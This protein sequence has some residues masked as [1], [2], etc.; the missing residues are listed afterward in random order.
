[1]K[2]LDLTL[3]TAAENV[4]LD[5]ALLEQA[6]QGG[7]PGELLRLW[8]LSS[9][10]VVIGRS[11]RLAEEVNVGAC[12]EL[13]IPILRRCS[14]GAAIVAGPGCLMYSVILDYTQ[15]PHLRML[16][17][18]HGFVLGVVRTA[19]ASLAPD[20][21][22][23]G[24]SDLARHGQKF[25]GNSLRCKRD[26]FLYHGTVLYRFPLALIG[27]C[28]AAA[29]R[30]PDYR[31]NRPHDAFVSNFPATAQQLR[32]VIRQG[33]SIQESISD[34]PRQQVARLVAQRYAR[35][36]WNRRL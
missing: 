34:W 36:D 12:Q 1:M 29:P 33:W 11:S 18:A 26:F 24:T 30:Q 2:L 9:P 28:L 31:R 21:V 20:V 16:D 22:M 23:M 15:R 32:R 13:G 8:E 25:S 35:D 14:G 27:Q 3:P 17:Q 5:E 7:G 6:E 10:S 19:L 4:A